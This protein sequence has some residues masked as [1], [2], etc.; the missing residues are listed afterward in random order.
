MRYGATRYGSTGS[1]TL[2][3]TPPAAPPVLAWDPAAGVPVVPPSASPTV[4]EAVFELVERNGTHVGWLED[5]QG[6]EW[7]RDKS[8]R[9]GA[10]VTVQKT[11]A[12]LPDL[13]APRMLRVR[14][15]GVTV[16][17]ALIRPRSEATYQQGEEGAQKVSLQAAGHLAVLDEVLVGPWSETSAPTSDSQRFNFAHPDFVMPADWVAA[18]QLAQQQDATFNWVGL[19]P[20]WP[21]PLAWWI[22]S[23]GDT[24]L[25]APDGQFYGRRKVT[26][27][28]GSYAV[29]WTADDATEQH[30]DGVRQGGTLDFHGFQRV[31][32]KFTAGEHTFAVWWGNRVQAADNPTG[33]LFALCPIDAAGTLGAPVLVSDSSWRILARPAYVPGWKIGEIANYIL[34]R[35]TAKS[36][37]VITRAWTGAVDSGAVA[38]PTV[39]DLSVPATSSVGQF[40]QQ[41]AETYTDNHMRPGSFTL[42]LWNKDGRGTDLATELGSGFDAVA[43]PCLTSLDHTVD[44]PYATSLLGHY[45]DGWLR[46]SVTVAGFYV[47]RSLEIPNVLTISEA[48]QTLADLL[49]TFGRERIQYKAGLFPRSD[50]QRPHIGF[51]EADRLFLADPA[52]TMTSVAVES[53]TGRVDDS[54]VLF[55]IEAGDL[56]FSQEERVMSWLQRMSDG[57]MGG[58]TSQSTST[59]NE[60]DRQLVAAELRPLRFHRPAA[61]TVVESPPDTPE[62]TAKIGSWVATV[63][64]VQASNVNVTLYINHVS[65]GV[66]ATVVAGDVAG[67]ARCNIPVQQDLTLVSAYCTATGFDL[68]V[69]ANFQ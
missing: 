45:A 5:G 35:G 19:P 34:D 65:S 27:P 51:S 15:R 14:Y 47:E 17:D 20:K 68:T 41:L 24:T 7:R 60:P 67:R 52:G 58:R 2:D 69:K 39:P 13:V 46:S 56:L 37:Q 38:W 66:T 26:I 10:S 21:A 22:A 6:L 31:D 44:P 42:D 4:P 53:I 12:V 32:I 9:G 40:L 3:L 1:A 43:L 25:N 49:A 61:V 23:S 36:G 33:F 55:D 48:E 57:A 30:V 11:S 50:A 29:C 28:A 18:T 54:K 63:D 59:K 62:E 16:Q 64:P 8:G